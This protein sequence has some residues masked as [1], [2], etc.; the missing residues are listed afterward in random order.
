MRFG[1]RDALDALDAHN[2]VGDASDC[3][4]TT[5]RRGTS[6]LCGSNRGV[7][8]SLG[9]KRKPQLSHWMFGFAGQ[10]KS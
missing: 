4:A 6:A 7:K 10:S 2:G 9:G 3:S 5:Y 1:V 8:P